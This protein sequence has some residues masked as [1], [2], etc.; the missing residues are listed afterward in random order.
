[1]NHMTDTRTQ[2]SNQKV[3]L[4]TGGSK[5][6]GA[7][8][9]TGLA[10]DDFEIA[11]HFRSNPEEAQNLCQEI[12][13]AQA[14]Q[15]DLSEPGA[16]KQ[17]VDQV[18][19]QFGRID[20]LVN[21]A[22]QSI[23][24]MITF[25]KEADFDQLVAVNLKPM[26]ML[27]KLVSKSMIKRKSGSIINMTSVVGHTGNAGQSMYAATKAA[28]TAMSHSIAKDLSPFGIRCNCVAPGFIETDMTRKLPEKVRQQ[29]LESI[30]L[31]KW[32][33]PQDVAGAVRFLA[34][35]AANYV[36]GTTIHVNGGMFS[37]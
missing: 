35:D 27:T 6:I 10:G 26:F 16:C 30:P 29:I 33:S 9:A 17:L 4:I 1:M 36:T 19:K 13:G 7:A 15:Y 2:T 23:D 5:G 31:K 28:I 3:A 21:N 14:F 18:L 20:V 24:Q 12:K 22:G 8:C 32:G 37:S 25:A 11:L 34:S